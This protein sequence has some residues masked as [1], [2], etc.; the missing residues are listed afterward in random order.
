V[1]RDRLRLLHIRD[2]IDRI[3]SFVTDRQTFL[4]QHVIQDA[5]IR[6]LEVIGE[7]TKALSA[8]TR[9]QCPDPMGR[10]C[11]DA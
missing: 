6:N 7:A 2:A 5:V 8:E 11:G 3:R 9:D 10:H 4:V 1:S